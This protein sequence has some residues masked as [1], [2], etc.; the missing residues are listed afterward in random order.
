MPGA[1]GA[2]S[3]GARRARAACRARA[4]CP[5]AAGRRAA[6]T[7]ARRGRRRWSNSTPTVQG[8]PSRI[9]SM[10][11]RRSASTCAA[12]GRRDMAGAVGGRRHDRPAECREQRCAT[13]CAGTRTRDAVEARPARDRDTP[14]SGCFGSTSVSGPGQNAAASCSASRIERGRRRRA[15]ARSATCAISGLKAAGPWPRRAARP[16]RH[17]WRRR[18]AHRPSRSGRRPARRRRGSARR[19]R[20]RRGIGGKDSALRVRRSRLFRCSQLAFKGAAVIRP[21]PVGV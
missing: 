14:Q 12:R 5:R 6:A 1:S 16:P 7:S 19:R 21:P 2:S 3:A 9:R 8:P 18:R 20:S 4:R 13:G 15:A 10:R 17:C 11:P